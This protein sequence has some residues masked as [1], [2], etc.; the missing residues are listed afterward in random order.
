MNKVFEIAKPFRVP[1]ETLV[2]PF[3]NSRDCMSSLPFNLLAGISMSAG[4]IEPHQQSRIHIMP[5]VTQITF[6]RHGDLV[7][8][9]KGPDDQEPYSQHVAV[10]QVVITERGTF[11]QLINDTDQP[12][13]VLYIV[14]PAY[15]FEMTDDKVVY[16]DSL[17]VEESWQEL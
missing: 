15:L 7:V 10:E 3:L 5:H 11:F 13:E 4:V 6:V 9:M 17:M 14:S 2:S 12:C 1:D 16:D 8:K